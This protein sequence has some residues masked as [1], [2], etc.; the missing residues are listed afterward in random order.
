MLRHCP[1]PG[2]ATA[3]PRRKMPKAPAEKKPSR[4]PEPESDKEP[5]PPQKVLRIFSINIIAQGLPFCRRRVSE[6]QP[7]GRLS[8]RLKCQRLPRAQPAPAAPSKTAFCQ[9]PASESRLLK[10]FVATIA[11]IAPCH[12]FYCAVRTSWNVK[13]VNVHRHIKPRCWLISA[14]TG[15]PE[16]PRHDARPEI[17]RPR[18]RSPDD[19]R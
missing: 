5:P 18:R 6:P 19:A 3:S 13:G 4:G 7:R 12:C 16:S 15:A 1:I 14:Y 2:F 17:P 9:A 10:N 11:F 8:T